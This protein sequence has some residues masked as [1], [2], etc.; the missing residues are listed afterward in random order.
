[1]SVSPMMTGRDLWLVDAHVH[2]HPCFN[3]TRFLAAALANFRT[4][5]ASSG[6]G[7][8]ITGLLMLTESMGDNAFEEFRSGTLAPGAPWTIEP[9]LEP[10]SLIARQAGADFIALIAGRQIVTSDRLEVLALGTMEQVPDGLPL[11][12]TIAQ[13]VASGGIPVLPWGFGKWWFKRGDLVADVIRDPGAETLFLGDNGGRLRHGPR[14]R[15]FAEGARRGLCVLPGSDPLP[16]ASQ[17]TRAGSFGCIIEGAISTD[18][19]GEA[20]LN[21]LRN[22]NRQPRV[23]GRAETLSRFALNQLRM[24]IRKRR[25]NTV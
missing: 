3:A 25:R 19:P 1:M 12:A 14:P 22:L 4:G 5:A 7:G 24:Q 11:R 21:L 20:L 18:R 6:I 15:L 10:C 9:T 16:F 17:T 13:V 23:F 2:F 8:P